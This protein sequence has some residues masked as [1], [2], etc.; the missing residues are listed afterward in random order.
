[1]S[2]KVD[3]DAQTFNGYLDICLHHGLR[4]TS[5]Q[6]NAL[7]SRHSKAFA[8]YMKNYNVYRMDDLYL[9]EQIKE[10]S[11]VLLKFLDPKLF[12]HI[13]KAITNLKD[14]YRLSKKLLDQL[15]GVV[16]KHIFTFLPIESFTTLRL[17]NARWKRLTTEI[18]EIFAVHINEGPFFIQRL[19]SIY[20]L[21][22]ILKLCGH[23]VHHLD[24]R[25]SFK[26]GKSLNNR[27][28][29]KIASCCPNLLTL[30]LPSNSETI[31]DCVRPLRTCPKL[32]ML[33]CGTILIRNLVGRELRS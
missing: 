5:G 8:V 31:L 22:G 19:K 32:E 25:N 27:T 21:I 26:D 11:I 3:I 9:L 14:E 30:Y 24:L 33:H 20:S 15:P 10:K 1:M 7:L 18:P 23:K 29:Q 12:D 6:K 4:R 16:I 13:D 17:V 2:L 28:F